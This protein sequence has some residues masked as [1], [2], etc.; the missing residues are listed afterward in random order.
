MLTIGG[1]LLLMAVPR[2]LVAAP[3]DAPTIELEWTGPGKEAVCLGGPGLTADVNEYLGRAA[4][5]EP[6]GELRVRVEVER[7]PNA[8]RARIELSDQRTNTPLG[9]REIVAEGALCSV[10]DEPLKLS[11]ALLVDSDLSQA[12]GDAA[13]SAPPPPPPEPEPA[14]EPPPPV[15]EEPPPLSE[16]HPWRFS[17]DASLLALGQ[18][19]PATAFGGE[20][21]FE[22]APTSWL[23]LRAH[24]AGF[25]PQTREVANAR[26]RASILYA[27]LA[28][29]PGGELAS[30][31]SALACF[32]VEAG[33]VS[34]A[35]EGFAGGK[36]AARRWLAA[37]LGVRLVRELGPR[38][39]LAAQVS[40]LFP[41][42]QDRFWAD[43][44]GKTQE[45][46]DVSAFGWVAGLGISGH[47]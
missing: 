35:R 28:L 22:A 40:A 5:S 29:C 31:W 4:I 10:L 23:S 39:S 27:G 36:N 41:A 20:L 34:V 30:G 9:E 33:R 44:D 45:L 13:R 14:P 47:L 32:G 3:V 8:W 6:P 38:L 17:L 7:L 16:S 2:V 43:V 19:L 42:R 24:G 26:Y 25:L 12:Q 18:L 46:F 15:D 11:V 1:G 37:S 21:G